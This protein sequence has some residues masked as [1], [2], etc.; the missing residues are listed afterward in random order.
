M[1]AKLLEVKFHEVPLEQERS[2]ISKFRHDLFPQAKSEKYWEV[3]A[4]VLFWI[5]PGQFEVPFSDVMFKTKYGKIDVRKVV[6]AF[7]AK[8]IHFRGNDY[9]PDLVGLNIEYK[10]IFDG[11]LEPFRLAHR[12]YEKLSEAY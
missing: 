5:K 8:P 10:F 12:Y 3:V 6:H 11:T 7:R 9:N 4:Q 2:F 1:K